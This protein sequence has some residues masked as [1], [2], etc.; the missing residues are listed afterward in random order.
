MR[1]AQAEA[2]QDLRDRG[3]LAYGADD[4]ISEHQRHR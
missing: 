4:P 2:D 3:L 1:T